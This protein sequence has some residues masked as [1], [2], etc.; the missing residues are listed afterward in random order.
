M[1]RKDQYNTKQKENILTTIESLNKDFCVKELYALLQ[2]KVGLTTIYRFIDKL[3]EEGRLRKYIAKDNKTYYQYL[4]EC[5][6]E[7]HFYLKCD[8]CRKKI[9]IDCDC[10]TDL[11]LHINEHHK[12]LPNK[13]NIVITGLCKNCRKKEGK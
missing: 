4:E 7:N 12:F 11:F 8:A 9:H 13:K 1:S 3:Q 2:Q 6:K 5:E 10:I